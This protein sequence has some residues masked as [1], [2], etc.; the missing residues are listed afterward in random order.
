[1]LAYEA[2]FDALR[3]LRTT[4]DKWK[5]IVAGLVVVRLVD[6][7][8]D[9]G[10]CAI[11]KNPASVQAVREAVARV[12][13]RDPIRPVLCDLM[14]IVTQ[15]EIATI[16]TIAAPMIGYGNMLES[17]GQWT[18]SRDV[19]AS[20]LSRAQTVQDHL[21]TA[22]TARRFGLVLRLLGQLD[23][24]DKAY[25]LVRQSAVKLGMPHIH[26]QS[27]M[28]YANNLMMRG[29]LVDAEKII[30]TAAKEAESLEM[31]GIYADVLIGKGAIVMERKDH[32]AGI[33]IGQSSLKYVP[34]GET[35]DILLA[36]IG[37]SFIGYG[38]HSAAKKILIPLLRGA[39]EAG[40][41]QRILIN[42][43]EIAA[44]DGDKSA[45][46]RYRK[47]LDGTLTLP[48]LQAHYH[49]FLG[50]GYHTFGAI[51]AA[52]EEQRIALAIAEEYGLHQA[53]TIILDDASVRV[54]SRKA[55][56]GG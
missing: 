12:P 56:V 18:L 54:L 21:T 6:D 27:Q 16:Q 46:E 14:D 40:S 37:A 48:V 25:N 39:Q 26:L 50:K 53:R 52:K 23:A 41:R 35:R 29:R 4:T 13:E 55:S 45:F 20:L 24:S 10:P 38:N 30:D 34:G 31:T 11:N 22:Y 1:M 9:G 36:N 2:Y 8:L 47:K 3:P 7:W 19:F 33:H 17:T 43:L 28:G 44:K 51:S 42:L 15:S 5:S 32:L 49:L